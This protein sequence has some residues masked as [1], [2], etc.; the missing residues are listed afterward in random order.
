MASSR[1]AARS[2]GKELGGDLQGYIVA[3]LPDH[4]LL[5]DGPDLLIGGSGGLTAIF[6][7]KRSERGDRPDFERRFALS[8]F[9]LPEGTRSVFVI[10]SE[11]DEKF[12]NKTP[13]TFSEITDWRNRG[14]IRRIAA[15][16]DFNGDQAPIDKGAYQGVRQ[17]FSDVYQVSKLFDDPEDR[18]ARR[19]IGPAMSAT[20]TVDT[21]PPGILRE[22]RTFDAR[23]SE[24]RKV[25]E[26]ASSASF[27]FDDNTVIL[28]HGAPYGLLVANIEQRFRG[29]PAKVIRA[30]AFAGWATLGFEDGEHRF[31]IEEILT[32]RRRKNRFL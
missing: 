17:R 19:M 16:R 23:G 3:I 8:R 32:E 10:R 14:I 22:E 15:D 1:D 31:R 6:F 5:M 2:L 24:I 30:A 28:K 18:R 12:A 11:A 29:D 4:P 9:A 7:L 25:I 21:P 20:S 13:V 27:T 26:E